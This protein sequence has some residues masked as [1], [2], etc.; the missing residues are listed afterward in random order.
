MGSWF[1]AACG[2]TNSPGDSVASWR[3]RSTVLI[4]KR[5]RGIPEEG[6][7]ISIA[8]DRVDYIAWQY[9][10]WTYSWGPADVPSLPLCSVERKGGRRRS[11]GGNMNWSGRNGDSLSKTY[12]VIRREKWQGCKSVHWDFPGGPVV[13]APNAGDWGSIPGQRT[14]SHILQPRVVCVCVCGVLS[15]FCCV[16]LFATLW[17]RQQ[18]WSGEP[19]SPPGYL[20]D[21]GIEPASLTSPALALGFFTTRTTWEAC[22]WKLACC[23]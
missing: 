2:L 23:N 12:G 4:K 15:C 11:R 6:K 14:R 20:P 3:L 17:T 5:L 13:H 1:L 18:Y 10:L 7:F 8:G 21:P 22:N 19:V 9:R 16:Q